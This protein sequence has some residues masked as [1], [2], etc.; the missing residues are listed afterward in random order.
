MEPD[1][2][3][4][5]RLMAQFKLQVSRSLDMAVDIDAMARDPGYAGRVLADVEGRAWD[6]ELR[7]T[8]RKLRER[9]PKL[10]LGAAA[11]REGAAA[12]P[13]RG[14]IRFGVRPQQT[15]DDQESDHDSR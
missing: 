8:L 5:A 7:A 2:I 14:F 3:E 6:A 4:T 12:V 11:A 9:L 10:L 1:Y 13:P 15:P